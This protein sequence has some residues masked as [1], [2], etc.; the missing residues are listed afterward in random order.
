MCVMP[1]EIP[2]LR[3]ELVGKDHDALCV[4]TSLSNEGDISLK[5]ELTNILRYSSSGKGGLF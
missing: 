4:T 2:A 3:E 5:F 1:I